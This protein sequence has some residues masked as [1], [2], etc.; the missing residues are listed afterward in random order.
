MQNS[1]GKHVLAKVRAEAELTQGELAALLH[2]HK[3]T[4]Q[5]IEQGL[6]ELS[7][8]LAERIQEVLGV[9]ASWLLTNNFEITEVTPEGRPWY[10]SDFEMAQVRAT[11]WGK[12]A[13]P[14]SGS[15]APNQLATL[16]EQLKRWR[17]HRL[18]TCMDS[19]LSLA[20]KAG[21]FNEF[22]LLLNRL[23][24]AIADTIANFGIDPEVLKAGE[25]KEAAL[26]KA[27]Q[28]TLA[29]TQQPLPSAL[30]KKRHHKRK[31]LVTS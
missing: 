18:M 8:S 25:P 3:M 4:I 10:K 14:P 1:A 31:N 21:R 9:S 29:A 13:L 5:R 7:V 11:A 20:Q 27:Y 6:L 30:P 16:T 23:E 12:V 22:G 19:S 17:L 15:E 24:N 2:C 28:R 26:R